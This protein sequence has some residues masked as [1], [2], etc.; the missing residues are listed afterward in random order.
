MS[1]AAA[2]DPWQQA[3]AI[4]AR[5]RAPVF[6][7]RDFEITRYGAASGAA[8]C[9]EA[10]ARAISEC[11][12]A[13]GGRVVVPVGIWLTGAIHFRSNVELHLAAGATLLFS[14][15]PRH[16][17]PL[18][19]TRW[20]G[21]ECLNYS[22]FVYADGQSNLAI[23]GAGT[24]DGQADCEHWWPWRGLADCG[25]AK[26]QPS[27]EEPRKLLMQMGEEDVPLNN[28]KFGEGFYLR[29]S[30]IQPV[31]S[32]NVLIEGVTIVNSPMF[33]IHPVMCSNIVVRNVK[34]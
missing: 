32:R 33:E 13:G 17:L 3:G 11:S 12:Q 31:R 30:F 27:Q 14:R 21:T 24:L 2:N 10:I 34:I 28:R 5:I 19:Y 8:D 26:G 4:L 25:W 1:L 18:V 16:Y 15:D 22:P 9:T 7:K 23:T 6:S 29:P 20:E